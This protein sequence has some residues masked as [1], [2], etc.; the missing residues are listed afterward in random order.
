LERKRDLPGYVLKKVRQNWYVIFGE[1]K[2]GGEKEHRLQWGA[3][4][5]KG[6]A[7][8]LQKEK[9][10]KKEEDMASG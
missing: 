8:G 4:E 2:W 9:I 5:R 3:Q 7:P 10:Y 1:K 6:A